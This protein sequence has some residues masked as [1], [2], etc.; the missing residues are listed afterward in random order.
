MLWGND[1]TDIA[2]FSQQQEAFSLMINAPAKVLYAAQSD[3]HGEPVLSASHG[4][5]CQLPDKKTGEPQEDAIDFRYYY[6]GL[7]AAL[8]GQSSVAF[9]MG[10]WSDGTPV[11]PVEKMLP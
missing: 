2:P 1:D 4:A 10:L 8:D 6:A 3:K 5:P 11:K 7:D 9:D